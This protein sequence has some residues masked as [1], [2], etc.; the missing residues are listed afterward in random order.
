MA[1]QPT[2]PPDTLS[3]MYVA[4]DG[5]G[6]E[7]PTSEEC[8][9][10]RE[11][12]TVGIFY[13][14]WLGPHGYDRSEPLLPDQGVQ[15]KEEGKDYRSPYDV[16][17]ILATPGEE[18]PWGPVH[19][20]HHWGEP[21]FG[22]Y[23]SNDEWVIAR[24]AR[25]LTDVG[26]DVICCDVTNA[27]RYTGVYMKICEVF[28]RILDA[29][30]RAPKIAFL[31]NSGHDQVAQAL[32][33]EFYSKGLYEDVWFRW[34]GK[35]LMLASSD[36]LPEELREFFTLR[37]SWAWSAGGWFGD[38]HDKWPWLDHTPQAFGWHEDPET[39]EQ[40]AVA[41]AQHPTTNIGRSHHDGAQPPPEERDP[42]QGWYF[43]EQWERALEVD[44]EFVFVTGWNEWVAMRF[45]ASE[46]QGFCGQRLSEGD[47]FFVD[48]YTQEYSR[49]IE[50]MAG[51]H[52]DAYYYQMASYLRRY[53]G[54]RPLPE[55]SA[56]LEHPQGAFM[57]WDQVQPVYRDHVADADHRDHPGWGSVEAYVNETGR[58]NFVECKVDRSEGSVHFWARTAEPITDHGQPG[59][60]TLYLRI[61]GSD[62]PD[63]SGFH[64]A[65][66]RTA[67]RRGVATL[68]R[69]L[70]G[71]E[72]EK[73]ADVPFAVEGDQ[74]ELTVSRH[75]LGLEDDEAFE[76]IFKWSDNSC[77]EGDPMDWHR[78]GDT[79][80]DGRMAYRYRG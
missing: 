72:W 13:F 15:P 69:S 75:L 6:R 47:T 19:A 61:P 73:V 74:I 63:W 3:D 65:I 38:G 25:M 52:G 56:P 14:T 37:Q 55:A 10:P 34:K 59:W 46:G 20:F 51:G 78:F 67:A 60:M 17:E 7:L 21:A 26:V 32:Y 43:Q 23:L 54:V 12:K 1:Q 70:G 42:A 50:P 2:H 29:G 64:F 36:G 57:N 44:P 8:G 68:E 33:D 45:L 24:H 30:G 77:L 39:P 62:A 35:P 28:Q 76:L 5:L 18:K 4:I 22:Y 48:Q 9:P 49:D 40:I 27:V 80:P 66:N 41:A 58:N 71:W 11:G 31:L 79:A 53:K 16:T